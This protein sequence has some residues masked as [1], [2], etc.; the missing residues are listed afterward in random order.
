MKKSAVVLAFA[1]LA[2][3]TA[4]AFATCDTRNDDEQAMCA[5]KCED[6]W[7]KDQQSITAD[8]SKLKVARKACD[9]KCGCPQNSDKL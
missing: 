8:I 2:G 3:L 4:P 9:T 7:L 5:T 1:L 6:A